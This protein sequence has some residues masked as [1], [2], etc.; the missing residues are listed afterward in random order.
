[1]PSAFGDVPQNTQ[2]AERAKYELVRAFW[3]L[4]KDV[5]VVERIVGPVELPVSQEN[6]DD[7]SVMDERG[8][9]RKQRDG[10]KMCCDGWIEERLTKSF[11]AARAEE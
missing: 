9:A 4:L 6:P 5:F 1:M 7:A 11:C 8:D 10:R 2:C 3:A